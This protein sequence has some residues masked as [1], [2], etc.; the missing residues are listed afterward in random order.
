M[1]SLFWEKHKDIVQGGHEQCQ[2]HDPLSSTV[3][4][5]HLVPNITLQ[6]SGS[7]GHLSQGI[8]LCKHYFIS[9]TYYLLKTSL[10]TNLCWQMRPQKWPSGNEIK[11]WD[12]RLPPEVHRFDP[13]LRRPSHNYF[14][15]A[16]QPPKLGRPIWTRSIILSPYLYER[17]RVSKSKYFN[18]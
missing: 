12:G 3:W 15:I 4:Q 1:L 11:A 16:A 9:F 6:V 17:L 7:L 2:F 13:Q 14:F 8:C 18:D 10:I 5:T